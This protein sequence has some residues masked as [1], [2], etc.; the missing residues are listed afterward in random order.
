MIVGSRAGLGRRE[1]AGVALKEQKR[2]V[3][4]VPEIVERAVIKVLAGAFP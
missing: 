1:V 2:W 4:L 3:E